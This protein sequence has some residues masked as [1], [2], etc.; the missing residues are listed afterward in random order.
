[1]CL[2]WRQVCLVWVASDKYI[3]E[4]T[5][6]IGRECDEQTANFRRLFVFILS[7]NYKTSLRRVISNG[8]ILDVLLINLM[9][10]ESQSVFCTDFLPNSLVNVLTL[11]PKNVKIL[12][13]GCALRTYHGQ[14]ALYIYFHWKSNR[15]HHAR[16]M[17][18][19]YGNSSVN[20]CKTV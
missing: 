5:L 7:N 12:I 8:M 15:G 19:N 2:A 17:A 10:N 13:R 16:A 4:T 11:A 1:V 6:L 9:I 14:F 18:L 3:N 20:N